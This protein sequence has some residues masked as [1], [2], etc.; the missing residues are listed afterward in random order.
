VAVAAQR[1]GAARRKAAR[2]RRRSNRVRHRFRRARPHF[3]KNVASVDHPERARRRGGGE[4]FGGAPRPRSAPGR[5]HQHGPGGNRVYP[6]RSRCDSAAG[7][8]GGV[9][10]C[11]KRSSRSCRE[12][13]KGDRQPARLRGRGGRKRISQPI[14]RMGS[15]CA[16]GAADLE[17][18]RQTLPF[19][20]GRGSAARTRRAQLRR[21]RG[22]RQCGPQ[23]WRE[24]RVDGGAH[25]PADDTDRC[26]GARVAA[27][28]PAAGRSPRRRRRHSRRKF[29]S[30]AF[31]RPH[32]AGRNL[33]QRRDQRRAGNSGRARCPGG[34][35]PRPADRGDTSAG[36][37]SCSQPWP[38]SGSPSSCRG[39]AH[40][41][42]RCSAAPRWW[43]PS[44]LHGSPT[45]MHGC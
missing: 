39:S 37:R 2:R 6:G 22:R 1:C 20:R 36:V 5:S 8:K 16:P 26:G 43:P 28:R 10:L 38:G 30:G 7:L 35:D 9:C 14:S 18:R 21:P 19:A 27:L 25:R 12:L 42:A 11:G 33:G 32:R 29:R 13:S 40:C 15:C 17:A 23:L 45:A 3:P 24:H 44:G 34:G 4:V 31:R 41:S